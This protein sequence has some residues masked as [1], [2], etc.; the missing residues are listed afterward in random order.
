MWQQDTADT[1]GDGQPT[2]QDFLVWCDALTYCENLSFA[3]HDDWRLPNIR[4]LQSLVDYGRSYSKIDPVFGLIPVQAV[5]FQAYWSSTW[6]Y[7]GARAWQ[8]HFGTGASGG[9]SIGDLRYVRAVR[10][11]RR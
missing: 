1:N 9:G 5:V 11:V 6:Y 2:D 10:S 7:I 3:G 8:V 4:E